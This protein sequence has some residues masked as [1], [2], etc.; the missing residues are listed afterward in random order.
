[1]AESHSLPVI[2]TQKRT[3]Q[4]N[5]KGLHG[6]KKQGSVKYENADVCGE[7]D[8]DPRPQGKPNKPKNNCLLYTS[9]AADE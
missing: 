5:A 9:D 4:A 7:G 8:E 6:L 2:P 3:K 1:M